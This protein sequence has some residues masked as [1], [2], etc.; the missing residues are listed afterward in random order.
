MLM[1]ELLKFTSFF[2][3]TYEDHLSFGMVDDAKNNTPPKYERLIILYNPDMLVMGMF[4]ILTRVA[5]RR[6]A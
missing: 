3:I 4:I 5:W 2:C 6:M 1:T